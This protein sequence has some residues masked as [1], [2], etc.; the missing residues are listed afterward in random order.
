MTIN[1]CW[2]IIEAMQE[3]VEI[4]SVAL[5]QKEKQRVI[6][7]K[8]LAGRLGL[9]FGWHYLLDLAWILSQLDKIADQTIMDAGAGVGIMQWY[10]AEHGAQVLSV[11]RGSRAHLAGKFRRNFSVSGV[12]EGDLLPLTAV[13][14]SR[15]PV[16]LAR[17][18]WGRARGFGR[19][20]FTSASAKTPNG[21]VLI[22]HQ[23]L[24]DLVDIPDQSVDAVVAVSSLEHNPPDDLRA[25]VAELM[26]V[27]KTG[28]PLLGTLGAAKQDWFHEPSHGW[29]YSEATLLSA[30]D[31]P[32]GTP[33]NYSEYDQLF[34][35]LRECGAL[36]DN[37]A[38]FYF[39]S[40]DNG[41]PWGIWDPQYQPVG[42][43]KVK[44]HDR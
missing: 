4:L 38:S 10:L 23:D 13:T 18:A 15:R 44:S 41:M 39:R 24:Q 40:G 11:D 3:K 32:V 25:V 9:E 35:E 1:S 21:E 27:L 36:R 6:E 42:V 14:A 2:M 19:E 5:L 29:C 30:F 20:I 17:Q 28:R 12:R 8:K 26:R 34:R 33:S 7:L 31:L 16:Q 37:L 22:Y 43:C